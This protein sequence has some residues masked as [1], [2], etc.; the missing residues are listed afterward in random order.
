MQR[1]VTIWPV[2]HCPLII[3]VDPVSCTN[4]HNLTVIYWSWQIGLTLSLG[5]NQAS[6]LHA[7]IKFTTVLN[8]QPLCIGCNLGHLV[9][10][11][12]RK[13]NFHTF[14]IVYLPQFGIF[15][16]EIT[17]ERGFSYIRQSNK[18]AGLCEFTPGGLNHMGCMTHNSFLFLSGPCSW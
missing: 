6:S 2:V 11:F 5:P 16:I 17:Q 18:V 3:G 10:K 7:N 12:S 14:A 9:L 15:G 4:G 8:S 1:L 13:K